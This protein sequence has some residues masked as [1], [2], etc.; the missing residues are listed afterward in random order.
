MN[1]PI[2]TLAGWVGTDVRLHKGGEHKVGNF[3]LAVTPRRFNRATEQ[4]EDAETQW[5]SVSVW[6]GLAEN[7]YM[8]LRRGNPVVV[9]GRLR[10]TTYLNKDGEEVLSL[11]IDATHVGH[12]LSLGV[13]S[14]M[15][16]GDSSRARA[17]RGLDPVEAV[18]AAQQAAG[19]AEVPEG[20]D[21]LTGEITGD[22]ERAVEAV[23]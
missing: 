14:F 22:D 16:T 15:R 19:T 13:T 17:E 5:F 11:E 20:V 4:W 2:V 1:E 23:A 10:T 3:R 9:S 8:S 21:P 12:D 6:R 7:C 18:A